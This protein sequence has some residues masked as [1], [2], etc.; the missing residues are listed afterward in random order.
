MLF[1][2]LISLYLKK[3]VKPPKWGLL[4]LI[5]NYQI[6]NTAVKVTSTLVPATIKNQNT[7]KNRFQ[8]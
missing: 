8:I 7:P 6:V 2:N 3:V 4:M 5:N 1:N